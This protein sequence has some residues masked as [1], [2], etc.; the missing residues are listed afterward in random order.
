MSIVFYRD[1]SLI[2]R[3]CEI[4]LYKNNSHDLHIVITHSLVPAMVIGPW[5]L[6][7]PAYHP[8]QEYPQHM[9]HSSEGTMLP[10]SS[11]SQR[12]KLLRTKSEAP[13][14]FIYLGCP[15]C[16]PTLASISTWRACWVIDCTD[17]LLE[18]YVIEGPY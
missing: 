9:K 17:T 4:S 14:L 1:I 13:C 10:Q 11:F 8:W 15:I 18:V 16:Y 5:N 7:F 2:L 6:A 3:T 12:Q